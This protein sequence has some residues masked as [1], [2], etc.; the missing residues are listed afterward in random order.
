MDDEPV[1]LVNLRLVAT[2]PGDQPELREPP[3][4]RQAVPGRR[5]AGFDGEWQEV[6]VWRRADLGAGSKLE[7]P[8][9][10]ELAES[11]VLL[12]P[13]WRGTVDDVGTLVLERQP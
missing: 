5:R 10:L 4:R 7:G 12:R 8:A 11:T 3:A 9:V 2:V 6:D 13:G 1:E